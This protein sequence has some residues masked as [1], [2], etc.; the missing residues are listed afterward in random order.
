MI[1]V[2]PRRESLQLNMAPMVDMIF[3]LV[4]FFLTTTSFTDK[5]REQDVL[6]PANRNPGSLSKT[7]DNHLIVNVLAEGGMRIFGDDVDRNELASII[8]ERRDRARRPLKV[9]VRADRRAAYGNVA[10]A[11][12][13]IERGG[14]QRPYIVTKIIELE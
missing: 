8:R 9:Q 14:V 10:M 7:A 13:S 3:L 1:R 5:E 4:I 6:L 2:E 12:E 11:L